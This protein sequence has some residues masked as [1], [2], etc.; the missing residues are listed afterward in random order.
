MDRSK[1][2]RMDP[3]AEALMR[4]LSTAFSNCPV[5]YRFAKELHRFRLE[6]GPTHWLY[7]ARSFVDDHT[8]QEIHESVE[9]WRIADAFRNSQRSR[10]LFLGERGV[11]E[12]DGNFGRDE[13][14]NKRRA[15]K[16]R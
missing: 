14:G 12:V 7:I 1:E 16:G 2:E 6:W 8:E 4:A 9:R 11:L 15:P 5:D 10:W 3:K 13:S